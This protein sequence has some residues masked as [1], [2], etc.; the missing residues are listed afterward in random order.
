MSFSFRLHLIPVFVFKLIFFF[1]FVDSSVSSLLCLI[2]FL[3]VISYWIKATDL[4]RPLVMEFTLQRQRRD[5]SS[6]CERTMIRS[7]S[8]GLIFAFGQQTTRASPSHGVGKGGQS[9]LEESIFIPAHQLCSVYCLLKMNL[10]KNSASGMH[11]S[12][13]SFPAGSSGDFSLKF[14][15]RN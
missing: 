12:S 3:S 6:V 1:V 5:H 8:F 13:S 7:Q 15:V 9:G 11:D 14:T 2:I 4:N 10:V